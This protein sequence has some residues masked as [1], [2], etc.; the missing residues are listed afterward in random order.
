[1]TKDPKQPDFFTP[2]VY[3]APV[4]DEISLMD[5]SPF[6]LSKNKRTDPI[7]YDLGHAKVTISGNTEYGI[8]TVHDY[9]I[10]LHMVSYLAEEWNKRKRKYKDPKT[11]LNNLPPT[12]YRPQVYDILKF[13][14]KGDGGDQY[15]KILKA[16]QRLATTFVM[17]E[18]T[19]S[20]KKRPNLEWD[21]KRHVFIE[22][23]F[24]YI[25]DFTITRKSKTGKVTEIEIE[26]PNWIYEG[27]VKIEKDNPPSIL[28]LDNDYFRIKK[29]LEKFLYRFAR[30][31]AGKDKSIWPLPTLHENSGMKTNY[32]MFKAMIKKIL[33]EQDN[34][35]LHYHVTLKESSQNTNIEFTNLPKDEYPNE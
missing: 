24:S 26:I 18:S 13:C 30:H 25:N 34:K 11:L 32:R 12:K 17:I 27:I 20:S 19:P 2:V 9:D 8:A 35:I 7:K 15:E 29:G 3:D 31:T 28:T 6:N 22:K 10:V 21:N 4:K 23:G 33:A 5:I 16:I 1:M 14:Q